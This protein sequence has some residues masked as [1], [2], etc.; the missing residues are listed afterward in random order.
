MDRRTDTS[1]IAR[2]HLHSMQRDKNEKKVSA[3]YVCAY[4]ATNCTAK[5][6][7]TSVESVWPLYGPVAGGTRVT[8]TGQYLSTVTHVHFAQHQGL[9]DTHRSV[10]LLRS[11]FLHYFTRCKQLTIVYYQTN[12]FHVFISCLS[13]QLY[14]FC[15]LVVLLAL[16]CTCNSCLRSPGEDIGGFFSMS[17]ERDTISWE[18][19]SISFPRDSISFPRNSISRERD[20]YVVHTR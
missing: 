4:F 5:P 15:N 3:I 10:V 13:R 7:M 14:V 20:S 1:V 2:P 16:L 12:M 19:D 11:I 17:W 6:S 9:I 18:R 8:I